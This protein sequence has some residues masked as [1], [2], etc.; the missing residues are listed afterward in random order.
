MKSKQLNAPTKSLS[1]IWNYASPAIVAAALMV[2]IG[3]GVGLSSSVNFSP[4][5]VASSQYADE[6]EL[7]SF[8]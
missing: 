3:L 5:N 2:G 6:L 8:C 7:L 4:E 1:S